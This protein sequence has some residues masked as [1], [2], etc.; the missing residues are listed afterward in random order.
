MLRQPNLTKKNF[1]KFFPTKSTGGSRNPL[2]SPGGSFGALE[3]PQ[4]RP[5]PE[6]NNALFKVGD[7]KQYTVQKCELYTVSLEWSAFVVQKPHT[8]QQRSFIRAFLIDQN[9]FTV[10][11]CQSRIFIFVNISRTETIHSTALQVGFQ[12]QI[13]ISKS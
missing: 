10:K 2:W 8:V 1:R 7:L 11:F 3:P 5:C 6:G 13:F 4:I 12:I 9:P